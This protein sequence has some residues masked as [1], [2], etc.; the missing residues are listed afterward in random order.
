MMEII[1][2]MLKADIANLESRD[3]S[4]EAQY[5]DVLAEPPTNVNQ[6]NLRGVQ[7]SA[8]GVRRQLAFL[9]GQLR[10]YA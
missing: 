5:A 1:K 9:R 3:A 4:I 2:E 8:D 6:E 7:Q 10:K